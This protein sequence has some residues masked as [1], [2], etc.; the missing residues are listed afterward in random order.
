MTINVKFVKTHPE[1][2]VPTYNTKND[3]GADLY[4][5]ESRVLWQHEPA[6]VETGLRIQLPPGYEAQIRPRS[7]LAAK[8]VTVNNSPATIDNGYTG[9][10]KV[11]L[12]YHGPEDRFHINSGDRIA[13]L[14]LAKYEQ[15]DV[16]EEVETLEETDRGQKGIGSSGR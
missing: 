8:G 7:G 13:Q 15:V 10:L 14:V 11:I 5:V 12:I 9:P 4:S 16:F 3:S 1:A 2:K 6:I